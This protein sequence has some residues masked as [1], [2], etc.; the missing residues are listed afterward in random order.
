AANS[1]GISEPRQVASAEG[2][3][4]GEGEGS[5]GSLVG[6][7]TELLRKA[8]ARGA[9]LT[10]RDLLVQPISLGQPDSENETPKSS[11][12][13][14]LQAAPRARKGSLSVGSFTEV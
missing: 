4:S 7:T 12:F 1:A 14:V 3:Q 8:A 6:V 11:A 13:L 9:A 2:S 5:S 10:S